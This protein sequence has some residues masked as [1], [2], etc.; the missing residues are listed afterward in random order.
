MAALKLNG[1]FCEM[2]DTMTAAGTSRGVG[3]VLK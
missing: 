2:D 1:F 3:G